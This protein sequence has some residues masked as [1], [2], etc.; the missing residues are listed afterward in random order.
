MK[1]L[2]LKAHYFHTKLSY[3]K[4]MLRQIKWWLQN[5]SITKNGVLPVSN[6]FFWK[7]CFS[8]RTSKKELICF[9]N[10]SN[11]HI[12]TFCKRWS[13]TWRWF[14]PVVSLR[15]YSRVIHA[16]SAHYL[17]RFR[18]IQDPGITGSSNINQHLL[19]KSCSSFKSLLGSIWNIF[20]FLF[21]QDNTLIIITTTIIIA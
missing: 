8:L 19:V 15:Y 13:F 9:I 12:C 17:G 11:A 18:H 10:N 5:G 20:L 1:A 6:L 3:R 16:C 14:S 21:L 2:R 7:F 4:P